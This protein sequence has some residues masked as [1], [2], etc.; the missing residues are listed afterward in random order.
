M[1]RVVVCVLSVIAFSTFVLPAFAWELTLKGD[2]EYRMRYWSRI[3]NKDLFGNADAVGTDVA[4]GEG[5]PV[6]LAGPGIYSAGAPVIRNPQANGRDPSAVELVRNGFA[7]ADCDAHVTDMR[8]TYYLGLKIV[9][10]IHLYAQINFGGYRYKFGQSRQLRQTTTGRPFNTTDPAYNTLFPGLP[11][12]ERYYMLST[13][14]ATGNTVAI[15]SLEKMYAVIQLPVGILSFG[16]RS[17]PIGTGATYGYNDRDDSIE[18]K[19]SY[20]PF[21]FQ[22]YIFPFRQRIGPYRFLATKTGVSRWEAYW[23]SPDP[24]MQSQWYVGEVIK[25]AQG[26]AEF[27]IGAFSERQ[28]IRDADHHHPIGSRDYD[29]YQGIFWAKY[30]NGRFFFN[31]EYAFENG[32]QRINAHVYEYNFPTYTEGY[33]AFVETGAIAGPVKLSFM[34]AQA[35]GPDRGT[36]DQ[37]P[38]KI[39]EAFPINYQATAPYNYLMFNT[40][41]GGTCGPSQKKWFGN[42]IHPDGTGQMTD[43]TALACR[44]DYALAA[45]LNIWGSYMWAQRLEKNG[46]W[47]GQFGTGNWY[48][49]DQVSNGFPGTESAADG[50][51]WKQLNWGG[52][53]PYN[54]YVDDNFIGWE[55]GFGLDWKLLEGLTF[56]AR[57]AYWQ[58]GGWFDQAFMAVTNTF[59]GLQGRGIMVDRSPI[60][61]TSTSLLVDF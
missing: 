50:Q 55:M 1:K 60:H 8:M 51:H 10:A 4:S 19:T 34:F 24:N 5:I 21:S 36:R 25:Y 28:H 12:F 31:A 38:T 40:Y 39:Y 26:P 61:A 45:N 30:F 2:F 20:G 37:N 46:Y 48:G 6:G 43:A 42:S 27:G 22:T 15:P 44:I 17:F 56:S 33:H 3:G 32:D 29:W 53:G 16:T 14:P 41:G 7:E 52:A 35:S 9:N 11:P 57:Y 54:P 18:L 59:Y 47:A 13:S 49:Y 23:Q 58:P